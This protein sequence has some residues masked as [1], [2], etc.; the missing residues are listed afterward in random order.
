VSEFKY[1]RVIFDQ[2]LKWN[3]HVNQIRN[4]LRKFIS[5]FRNSS[6]ILHI[7][8]INNVYYAY[9][10]S[11]LQFGILAW[12]GGFKSILAPIDIMQKAI[13]KIALRKPRRYP[14]DAVFNEFKVLICHNFTLDHLSF[15]FLKINNQFSVNSLTP[16]RIDS[17]LIPAYSC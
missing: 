2:R 3:A 7:D 13:I 1:L 12:G 4:K 10:Q 9:V 16:T 5:I 6:K 11:V 15:I 14:T 17:Q 8:L